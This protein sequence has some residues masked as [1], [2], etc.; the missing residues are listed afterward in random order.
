MQLKLPL[1]IKKTNIFFTRH[2]NVTFF[3]EPS[4]SATTT[5]THAI[6]AE[7]SRL[8]ISYNQISIPPIISYLG[9]SDL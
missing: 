2:Y 4:V 3:T 6:S 5:G 9:K 8:T 1:Q 7:S